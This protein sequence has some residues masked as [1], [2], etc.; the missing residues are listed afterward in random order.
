MSL[1]FMKSCGNIMLSQYSVTCLISFTIAEFVNK[2][3]FCV[4][5]IL[6]AQTLGDEL[7][8]AIVDF[9]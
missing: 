5:G 3:H 4:G 1:A 7:I 2:W 8:F 9:C 6:R